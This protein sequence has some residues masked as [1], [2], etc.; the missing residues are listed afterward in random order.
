MADRRRT[1]DLAR[2]AFWVSAAFWVFLLGGVFATHEL[3]PYQMFED[4]YRAAKELVSEQLQT[5]PGLLI[6]RRYDGNGVTRHEP[7]RAHDGLTLMEGWFATGVELRLVDMAG[8]VVHR[9]PADFFEIWPDPAHVIPERNVPAGR[10]NYHTH[11]TWLLPDGSAVVN[12]AELGTV[13]M[14]KC[15]QVQWTVNRMTHHSITPNPDGSFWIPAKGDVR[16]V[17]E[18]LLLPGVS[19]AELLDSPGWYED[20]LLLIRGDGT[21]EREISVLRALFQSGFEDELFD[22]SL[23]SG[24]DPTHVNDIEVVTPAL[25][26]TI[27]GVEAGDLL[28]SIRQMHMLAI[29]DDA[30]GRIKWHQTGPWVRQHDPDITARGTIEVFDNGTLELSLDRPPGSSVIALDPATGRTRTLYPRPGQD[31]FHTPIMGSHQLLANGNRLI[32]E[33]LAGRV[34]E[35]DRQGDIVW[36][37]VEPFD[38]SYAAMIEN[39]TRYDKNYFTVRDWRCP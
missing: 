37:Y 22:V 36:E 26:R 30:T 23:I 13:K 7:G 27:D 17:P 3:Q 6:E 29:L 11:G 31:G 2:L 35:I 5:R 20:R 25:A 14:D 9:W 24:S 4:G 15:G 34:F 39:A 1:L 28:I 19:E 10:F 21:I 12:F 32:T 18:A 8:K 33:S 16:K 38:E